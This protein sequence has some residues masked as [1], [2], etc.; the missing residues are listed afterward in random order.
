MWACRYLF[1]D[2][3]HTGLLLARNPPTNL[4]LLPTILWTISPR[5]NLFLIE[6]RM[7]S[8]LLREISRVDVV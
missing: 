3:V 7:T 8:C 5:F 6:H 1:D 2:E 4:F